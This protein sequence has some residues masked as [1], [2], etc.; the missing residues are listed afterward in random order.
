MAYIGFDN[1]ADANKFFHTVKYAKAQLNS[2]L[3]ANAVAFLPAHVDGT[4]EAFK[5]KPAVLDQKVESGSWRMNLTEDA[6]V[7]GSTAAQ[8]KA[9]LKFIAGL[10]ISLD[11]KK[12]TVWTGASDKPDGN[13]TGHLKRYDAPTDVKGA[14]GSLFSTVERFCPD[15]SSSKD[16]PTTRTN[17]TM[18]SMGLTRFLDVSNFKVGKESLGAAKADGRGKEFGK[19]SD[20]LSG[21]VQPLAWKSIVIGGFTAQRGTLDRIEFRIPNKSQMILHPVFT[22]K[23]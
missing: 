19:D 9:Y 10:G 2:V 20:I 18:T 8:E 11:P 21:W 16:D 12:P 1:T 14:F 3:V 13:W 7:A 22:A 23:K 5:R 6:L 4:T 17:C 15:Q